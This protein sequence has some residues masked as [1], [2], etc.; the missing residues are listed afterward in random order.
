MKNIVKV[1]T[2][3]IMCIGTFISQLFSLH[4]LFTDFWHV[5]LGI[6]IF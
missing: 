2:I 4:R 6:I 5:S 3:Y 1:E